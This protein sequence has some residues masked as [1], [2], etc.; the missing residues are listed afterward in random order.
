MHHTSSR[1]SRWV[2]LSCFKLRISRHNFFNCVWICWTPRLGSCIEVSSNL[3]VTSKASAWVVC[4]CC[5]NAFHRCDINDATNHSW[6]CLY[7]NVMFTSRIVH[8]IL[9]SNSH[10]VSPNDIVISLNL[11]I[12][13][14]SDFGLLIFLFSAAWIFAIP[15]LGLSLE[16]WMYQV[17]MR[18]YKALTNVDFFIFS[19]VTPCASHT[20]FIMNQN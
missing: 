15:A 8:F 6:C 17:S 14:D 9:W 10:G 13:C 2:V 1:I 12:R 11:R 4:I 16:C 7:V 20:T 18:S 19:S 3:I 5:D